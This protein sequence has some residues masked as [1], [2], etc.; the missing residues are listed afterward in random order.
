ML[1][2]LI[3]FTINN[4]ESSTSWQHLDF[5]LF[6]TSHFCSLA[7]H[8][9]VS[10]TFI[11]HLPPSTQHRLPL[12]YSVPASLLPSPLSSVAPLRGIREDRPSHDEPES[13]ERISQSEPATAAATATGTVICVCV[14]FLL[15]SVKRWQVC[16]H[17]FSST[18]IKKWVSRL[19]AYMLWELPVDAYS[20]LAG[21][22]CC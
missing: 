12:Q 11:P 19:W 22:K 17:A 2:R 6:L 14:C 8:P 20:P 13:Q 15:L 21:L 7:K 9:S 1:T 3:A 5:N 18:V 10:R 16:V 4:K